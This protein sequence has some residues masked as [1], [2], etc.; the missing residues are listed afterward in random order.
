MNTSISSRFYQNRS[1][2]EDLKQKFL[3]IRDMY[4]N[5]GMLHLWQLF[6]GRIFSIGTR[7]ISAKFYLRNC[8][9]KGVKVTVNGKPMIRNRGTLIL[10]NR[11]AIWSV[12]DRTKLLVHPGG[13]LRIGSGSRING[14]HISVKSSVT[15]GENVHIG[16]YSLIMDSDFHDV[17]DTKK[18]GKKGDVEIGNNVWIASKVTILKGVKIGEGAI[19]A[20]GAVITKDVPPYCIAAGVP[21]KVIKRIKS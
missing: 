4:P 3:D 8:T 17:A 5:A 12:F 15:I 19:I 20:A 14:V 1:V 7:L 13:T 18:E 9:D 16:P 21:G 6:I 10:G 11:V 2:A